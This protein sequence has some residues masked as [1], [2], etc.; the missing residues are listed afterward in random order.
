MSSK[1][2][3]VSALNKEQ[4]AY[5]KGWSIL[6]NAVWRI[7]HRDPVEAMGNKISNAI[8]K[9]AINLIMAK[10]EKNKQKALR[11]ALERWLNNVKKLSGLN[12]KRRVLLKHIINSNDAKYKLILSKYFQKWKDLLNVSEKE[13][14]DKYGALFKFL[15]LLKNKALK[16]RKKSFLIRLR[17]YMNPEGK[18][19]IKELVNIYGKIRKELLRKA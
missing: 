3:N 8:F 4:I 7:C 14:R 12:D 1:Q 5:I 10:R 19:A 13:I 17:K 6:Q 15:E 18:N 2:R 11:S 9:S 16:P